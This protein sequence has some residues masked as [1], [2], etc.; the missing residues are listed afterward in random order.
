MLKK[1]L[2]K[3]S[4]PKKEGTEV[5]LILPQETFTVANYRREGL[6]GVAVINTGLMDFDHQGVFC[7]HLSLII[8]FDESEII[9]NGMPSIQEREIVE[10]FADKLNKEIKAGGNALFLA[11]ET[12]NKTRR[13]VWMVYD[14]DIAH[15]HLQHLI[16][17][18]Q[19]PRYFDYQ[20]KMDN[21]WQ[22]PNW[23]FDWIRKSEK[24]N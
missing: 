23:Y 10:A 4:E 6:P 20:M 11:R 24:S 16:E 18:H 5:R 17:H 7:W 3:F 14:P 2:K 15:E 21:E 8:D 19:Y 9:D 1:L 22:Q 13:L 12:W